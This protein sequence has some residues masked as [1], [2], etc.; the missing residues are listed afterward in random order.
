MTKNEDLFIENWIKYHGE[1]FGYQNLYI[2]DGSDQQNIFDV[3]EKYKKRGLNIH[4]TDA[5][6]N[7][8]E[9][10]I[11]EQIKKHKGRDNFV[12]KMDT[13]EFLSHANIQNI[14]NFRYKCLRFF[15]RKPSK[16]GELFTPQLQLRNDNFEHIFDNLPITGQRYIAEF[17]FSIPKQNE[18]QEP[19]KEITDFKYF[20][21]QTVKKCLFHADSFISTDLGSHTGITTN[22]KGTIATPIV[23]IHYHGIGIPNT[24]RSAKQVLV[25]HGY[26]KNTDNTETAKSKLTRIEK[27]KDYPSHHKVKFYLDYLQALESGTTLP[28]ESVYG[29]LKSSYNQA[30]TFRTSLIDNTLEKIKIDEKK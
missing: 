18:P 6:L 16:L 24:V 25:S 4:H 1:I 12:I 17:L 5:N 22:N 15:K 27:Q 8:L 7:D 21:E 29:T 3:Y 2:I 11:N 10:I 9:V 14:N 30:P 13:D 23:I 20:G 28:P 19:L 26:I